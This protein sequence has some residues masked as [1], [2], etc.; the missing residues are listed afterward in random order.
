[1]IVG[2]HEALAHFIR[3]EIQEFRVNGNDRVSQLISLY[4]RCIVAGYFCA[5]M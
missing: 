2:S 4:V 1:M 5:V 3:W